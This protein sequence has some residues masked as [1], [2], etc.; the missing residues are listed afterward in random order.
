MLLNA[1]HEGTEPDEEM[2]PLLRSGPLR[3][4]SALAVALAIELVWALTRAGETGPFAAGAVSSVATI[5]HALF[6]TYA[7]P[8][9]VTSI[10]ILVAMVGAVV[11]ASREGE[12]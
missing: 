12:R 8:F 3:L 10:L 9:E 2:H 4:G 7:F 1:P 6:T 5:G 11:L